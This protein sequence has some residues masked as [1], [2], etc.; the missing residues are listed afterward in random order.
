MKITTISLWVQMLFSSIAIAL[1]SLLFLLPTEN[2]KTPLYII[3]I[4]IFTVLLFI[5][6]PLV[7]YFLFVKPIV[8]L[9]FQ[10][11]LL[12]QGKKIEI[13]TKI[14]RKFNLFKYTHQI[15]NRF[16]GLKNY[17]DTVTQTEEAN[18][19]QD[20][21]EEANIFT[22]SLNKLSGHLEHL[23]NEAEDW[24]SKE[25]IRT[26][27]NQGIAMF[28]EL[29]RQN[30]SSLEALSQIF[31][32]KL[33]KYIDA[34]QG[35][36]FIINKN[37]ETE[38]YLEMI[39]GYAYDRER[40]ADT[41]RQ[42][43]DGLL[44]AACFE[45]QSIYM[46]HLPDN[47]INIRSG[48]G[49]AAPN[50]LLIVPLLYDNE[51]IGAIELASFKVF[52]DHE[53]TFVEKIAESLAGTIASAQLS[54]ATADLLKQSQTQ[55]EAL[56]R[57]DEELRQ[58]IEEMKAQQEEMVYKQQELEESKN[59]MIRIIDLVPFP[60]FVKNIHRQYIVANQEQAKLFNLPVDYLLGKSDDE[61]IN[62]IDELNQI[63]KTDNKVLNENQ[64]IKLPE[65][66]ISLPDGT[67]RILQTIKVPF[68][69]DVTKNPNILGV[70]IDHTQMR[71]METKL[72][73]T[74]TE[75]EELKQS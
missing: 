33:I 31:L 4:Y 56:L 5:A 42:I 7:H 16:E 62:D 23:K 15:A 11:K 19:P 49:D 28:S 44:G 1:T 52:N 63:L 72:K 67:Q 66:I 59:L 46:T 29:L 65:Q 38:P 27:S 69:N 70:S 37:S 35:G 12:A 58:H 25:A 17:I 32:N 20:H 34:N 73:E 26:W 71:E 50:C 22:A 10:L 61:L 2:S 18:E 13:D 41:K 60:I 9:R 75:I 57:Q 74:L 30:N 48:M 43:N 68:M 36:V 47:Y 24:K 45:K 14:A 3:V 21:K 54:S 39:A 40:Y 6:L 64:L 8:E 51:V 53:K 55:A